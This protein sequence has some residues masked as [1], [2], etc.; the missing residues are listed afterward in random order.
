MEKINI[1][2]LIKQ[3]E[4]TT[5]VVEETP[6]Q[7]TPQEEVQEEPVSEEPTE[8]VNEEPVSE[9]PV[10]EESEPE[11]EEPV[12]EPVDEFPSDKFGGKFNSWDEVN[13]AL[14]NKE[15][16]Y[17]DDFIKKVVD[18]YNSKGSLEDFFKAYS[19]NWKDMPHDDLLKAKFREE[20]PD[21]DPDIVDY[22]WEKK[23]AKEYG[24][25]ELLSRPDDELDSE[26]L[27]EKKFAVSMMKKDAEKARQE[28]I[29]E[30]EGY[31]QPQTEQQ[32]KEEP[33]K[34]EDVKQRVQ[35]IPEVQ[36]ILKD[37]KLTY[38]IGDS[39]FN[40]EV[41]DHG[42]IIDTL[43]D[44]RILTNSFVK[45]G[46]LDINGWVDMVNYYYNGDKVRQALV[47]HGRTLEREAIIN[48]EYKNTTMKKNPSKPTEETD[49]AVALMKAFASQ[50]KVR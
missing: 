25:P 17:K 45:D 12:E 41:T 4:G 32:P 18:T 31:L 23:L 21:L 14:N 13:E 11:K 8:P 42:K 39:D 26:E 47:D 7:E 48:D 38:K 6:V 29:Q 5:E 16:E 35:K 1:D 30:Q 40:L 43:A 46:K 20:N 34:F 33:L 10:S 50:G 19:T 27:K 24:D 9:E 2:E 49:K 22:A 15:P 28:K 37:K 3:S 36:S 44:E